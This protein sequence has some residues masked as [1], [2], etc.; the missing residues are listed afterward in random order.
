[1]K[2]TNDSSEKLLHTEHK[3][4]TATEWRGGCIDTGAQETVFGNKQTFAYC[5]FGTDRHVSLYA[6][7]MQMESS[8][9]SIIYVS[10]LA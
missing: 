9:G 4:E 5:R 6:L 2:K 3:S 1:M 8:D 10:T 7:P